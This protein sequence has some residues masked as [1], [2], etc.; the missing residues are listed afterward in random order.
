MSTKEPK[1]HILIVQDDA[2]L[3][4]LLKERLQDENVVAVLCKDGA[5]ALKKMQQHIPDLVV[6]GLI[7]PS[8]SGIEVLAHMR[9]IPAL[10]E[11]PVMILSQIHRREDIK[12]VRAFDVC[13]FLVKTDY[14]LEEMIETMLGHIGCQ[15]NLLLGE[16]V[17]GS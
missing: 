5:E 12:Q 4:S 6:L 16:T 17:S 8:L 9:R 1:K 2:L 3:N 14:T 13:D 7:L 15:P 11:T 10:K